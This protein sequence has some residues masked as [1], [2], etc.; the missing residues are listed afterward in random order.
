MERF[1]PGRR[2]RE[3]GADVAGR[4]R[5][6]PLMPFRNPIIGQLGSKRPESMP[7]EDGLALSHC[8]EAIRC[9]VAGLAVNGD[10]PKRCEASEWKRVRVRSERLTT[11]PMEG[12]AAK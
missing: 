11:N 7:R 12:C 6:A 10:S 9:V 2:R 3:T 1:A 8:I 4:Q 5:R